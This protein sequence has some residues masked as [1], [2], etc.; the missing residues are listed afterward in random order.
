MFCLVSHC[1]VFPPCF[2]LLVVLRVPERSQ[3]KCGGLFYKKI[4]HFWNCASVVLISI[5][6]TSSVT[7]INQINWGIIKLHV[8]EAICVWNHATK[9]K[10]WKSVEPHYKWELKTYISPKQNKH[11]HK[12]ITTH[13]VNFIDRFYKMSTGLTD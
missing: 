7:N 8:F 13:S 10:A 12:H 6:L 4:I 9:D 3:H 5:V 1:L 2:V 11:E